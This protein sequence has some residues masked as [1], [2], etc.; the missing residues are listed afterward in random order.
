MEGK[1]AFIGYGGG[2]TGPSPVP[3][4]TGGQS[5]AEMMPL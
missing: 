3:D 4:G 5:N 1:Y 2:G